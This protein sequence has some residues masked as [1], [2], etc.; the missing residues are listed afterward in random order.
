L[1]DRP[2]RYPAGTEGSLIREIGKTKGVPDEVELDGGNANRVVRIGDTVRRPA[3]PWT[4]AVH[5]L[6]DH[7]DAAS[8]PA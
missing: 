7:Y 3:G 1:L 5:C 6:L 8:A 4:P 2:S